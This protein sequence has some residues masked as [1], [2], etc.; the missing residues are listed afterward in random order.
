MKLSRTH[1]D[2]PVEK[3]RAQESPGDAVQGIFAA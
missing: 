1:L 3:K 2:L